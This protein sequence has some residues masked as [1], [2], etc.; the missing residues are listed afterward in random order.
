MTALERL[1][2]YFFFFSPVDTVQPRRKKNQP[3]TSSQQWSTAISTYVSI[4]LNPFQVK[5]D[6]FSDRKWF[7]Q[8]NSIS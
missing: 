6:K 5:G 2:V 8:K 7:S 4:P 3:F 1:S